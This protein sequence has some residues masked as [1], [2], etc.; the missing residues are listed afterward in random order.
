MSGRAFP[1][2]DVQLRRG[3]IVEKELEAALLGSHELVTIEVK[4]EK[5]ART[6]VFVEYEAYGKPS[7]IALSKADWYTF[8]VYPRRF[9]TLPTEVLNDM[10]TEAYGRW[11]A[12]HGGEG[13]LATGV[14]IPKRWLIGDK[15]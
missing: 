15:S 1:A 6:H 2:F 10:V 8:E 3:Q 7:G 12:S 14:A 13:G 4:S 5:D 11:G 9:V